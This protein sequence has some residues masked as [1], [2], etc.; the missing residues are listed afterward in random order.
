AYR[1][2]YRKLHSTDDPIIN[3]PLTAAV[4]HASGYRGRSTRSGPVQTS[5]PAVSS[6]A[7]ASSVSY[8]PHAAPRLSALY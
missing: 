1:L 7:P 8:S 3:L 6:P 5:S 4:C 2:S